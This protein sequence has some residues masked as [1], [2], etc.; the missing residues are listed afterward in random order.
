MG[1]GLSRMVQPVND[2]SLINIIL[3]ISGGRN[4]I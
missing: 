3:G 1:E 2:V 4:L